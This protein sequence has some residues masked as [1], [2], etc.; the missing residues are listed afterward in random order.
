LVK[1]I[2][3]YI[4][5]LL[6]ISKKISVYVILV[7]MLMGMF[8]TG[9]LLKYAQTRSESNNINPNLAQFMKNDMESRLTNLQTQLSQN[10]DQIATATTL[11]KKQLELNTVNLG[12]QIDSINTAI[13]MNVYL[14]TNYYIAQA[15]QALSD[16]KI[17]Y[18]NL[19]ALPIETLT[20]V[21]KDEKALI[22]S[23]IPRMEKV[24]TSKDFGE[25][26][27]IINDKEKGNV[28]ISQTDKDIQLEQN[29]LR[30]KYN[31]TN[32]D[33]NNTQRNRDSATTSDDVITNIG[34]AR[35]SLAYNLDFST[36]QNI[37]APLTNQR[38]VQIKDNITVDLKQLDLG[39]I[40]TNNF[41]LMKNIL[42]VGTYMI[43]ILLLILA[44]GAISQ[45]ISTGSIKSLI[46]SPT[47]RWKIYVAKL[48]SLIT[49][50]V[51][52]A[53]IC[54][55]LGIIVYGVFFGLSNV[56]PYIYTSSS[57]AILMNFYLFTFV[58]LFIGLIP[59]AFYM[60]LALMLSTLTR[61]TAA[62]VGISIGVL[63]GG[64]IAY[65]VLTSLLTG[66]W[67]KFL[68][69]ANFDFA[70]QIFPLDPSAAANSVVNTSITFSTTY[71]IIVI[72]LMFYIGLD[73]F[74]RRDIK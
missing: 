9:G 37:A 1:I 62:S 32:L 47:K 69:F 20:Q 2:A 10:N 38:R 49:V 60:V 15:I 56:S 29:N 67:L 61:N 45:E 63:F 26:T 4:N 23:L 31:V 71:I 74:N 16:Y 51:I 35:R 72:G 46:I 59:V 5:E 13:S 17:E 27:S 19:Q 57:N 22:E 25:Y 34:T 21:Q 3:L 73:S 24:I 70:S 44:G 52:A 11:Q 55:V 68:P 50:G 14:Y 30:L 36:Q 40:G 28:D 64:T 54:Y 65:T 18:N 58:K 41:S 8:V 33:K 53:G 39:T 48:M 66:E 7:I 42:S 43:E 12:Y 6:K